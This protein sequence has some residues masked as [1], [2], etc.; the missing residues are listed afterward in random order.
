VSIYLIR[1]PA[2]GKW[3]SDNHSECDDYENSSRRYSSEKAARKV[4]KDITSWNRK[5]NARYASGEWKA[6]D[7]FVPYTE[8]YEVVAFRLVEEGVV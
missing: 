6:W 2:N 3:L 7:G 5:A 8:D 1:N 4:I